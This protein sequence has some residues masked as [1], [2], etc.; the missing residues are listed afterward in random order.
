[1]IEPASSE[2]LAETDDVVDGSLVLEGEA[3]LGDSLEKTEDDETGDQLEVRRVKTSVAP[4]LPSLKEIEIHN[5]GHL[6]Y[7]S[8]CPFCVAGK[9]SNTPHRRQ[10][11]QRTIP[12]LVG[13]FCFAKSSQDAESTTMFVGKVVPQNVTFAMAVEVKGATPANVARLAKVIR[14][15]GLTK[16]TYRSDQEK[17]VIALI[18]A[19]AI[20]A[21]RSASPEDPV[22]NVA[23]ENSA[24]GESASNGLAERTVQAVEDQVRTLL[25]ALESRIK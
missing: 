7:R 19:A 3:M 5:M 20:S 13:D 22:I 8:W 12:L 2:R 9:R 14:D 21:Q 1:M 10:W 6:T 25:L 11:D 17:A 23:P 18:E 15:I 16:F 4:K 24:V